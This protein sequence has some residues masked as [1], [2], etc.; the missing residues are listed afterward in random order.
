MGV[1]KYVVRLTEEERAELTTLVSKG[2]ASARKIGHARVLLKVDASGS[3]WT[4]QE[5][6]EAF[7]LR[8]NT[9]C[10]TSDSDSSKKGSRRH[11]NGSDAKSR[12]HGRSWMVLARR[13]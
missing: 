9:V 8:A 6:A 3:A 1:K 13:G 5:A 10:E 4:D 11:W 7:G 12:R 2:R